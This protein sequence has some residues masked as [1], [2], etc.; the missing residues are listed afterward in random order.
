MKKFFLLA[1]TALFVISCNND[2]KDAK[3]ADAPAPAAETK[4]ADVKYDYP[5]TLDKPY[6]GWL[7]GDQQHAVNALKSLKAF[8]TGDIAGAVTYFGDSVD[9]RFDNWEAKLSNDSLKKSFTAQRALY[10][11]VVI[12]MGDWES[13]ISA[14]KKEEWVTM[15]YKEIRTSKD[16]KVD[17]MSV[18]DDCKIMNGKIVVLDSKSRRIPAAKK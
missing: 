6:Q 14:D 12:K 17:S 18:A 4:T 16:G 15:W 8:E 1:C 7:P 2:S 13:V 9:V 5:Y 10:S 3:T 11:S